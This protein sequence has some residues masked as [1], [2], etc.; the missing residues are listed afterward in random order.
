VKE[1]VE[2]VSTKPVIF[3]KLAKNWANMR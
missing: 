2:R 3:V 1:E